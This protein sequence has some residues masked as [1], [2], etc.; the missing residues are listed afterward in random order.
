M[1]AP[2]R[3]STR[4]A[5]KKGS[6]DVRPRRATR[7]RFDEAQQ[8]PAGLQH[9]WRV[10]CTS[11]TIS[12]ASTLT[13]ITA[14][15]TTARLQ[16][17][18]HRRRRGGQL[19]GQRRPNGFGQSQGQICAISTS[20]RRK[21]RLASNGDGRFKW[22]VG[23]FYFDSRDTTDFYQRAFSSTDRGAQPEQLG[24]AAQRQH[25]AG[26]CSARSATRSPTKLTLTAGGRV[27]RG[28]QEDPPAQDRRHRRRRRSPIP[29]AATC[30]LSDT[31]PSWDV[32]APVRGDAR[33][34]P[35]CPR[36][37][38]ASAARPS[39]AVRRC[40][41]PTS[42]PPNSET[43]TVVRGGL[44]VAACST[45]RCASTPRPSPTRSRT[46]S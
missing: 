42:P 36:R 12:A 1:T 6:N 37:A 41:T 7:S 15:E 20:G 14:Y 13:S 32:S 33:R 40:S 34:Q 8:Q 45:T 29:A 35:L 22:Q 27:H 9:L 10:G 16:P 46:S 25:L 19:P 39:R 28:Q 23:G 31:Q 2:R 24:A 26:R 4:A 5:L 18:R 38:A 30:A 11:P 17:R 44:Q 43:I 21:L 3:C